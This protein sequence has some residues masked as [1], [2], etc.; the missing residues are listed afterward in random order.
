MTRDFPFTRRVEQAFGGQARLQGQEGLVQRTQ[1]RAAHLLDLD[2]VLAPRLVKRDARPHLDRI[3]RT[4]EKSGGQGAAAE[5][6]SPNGRGLVLQREVPVA[7][8][9]CGEVGNFPA[10]PARGEVFVK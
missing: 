5:H 6:D 9:C 8:S 4:R 2:L 7:R 1:P 3:A 10:Y